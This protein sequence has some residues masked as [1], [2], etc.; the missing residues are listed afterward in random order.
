MQ[1]QICQDEAFVSGTGFNLIVPVSVTTLR[2]AHYK[3]N[4]LT[5]TTSEIFFGA[6]QI[7]GF[8]WEAVRDRWFGT[9]LTAYLVQRSR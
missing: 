9:T 5:Q 4:V 7:L 8:W 3:R 6:A 1:L 2:N